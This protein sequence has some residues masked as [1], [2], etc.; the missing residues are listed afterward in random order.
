[1]DVV[2]RC[3]LVDKSFEESVAC[4]QLL[5]DV[6]SVVLT[7]CYNALRNIGVSNIGAIY[8]NDHSCSW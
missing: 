8:V 6:T 2:S 7:I 1:M 5:T 4:I 3:E